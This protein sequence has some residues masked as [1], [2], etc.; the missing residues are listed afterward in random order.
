M[1]GIDTTTT[2]LTKQWGDVY[3]HET[4]NAHIRRLEEEDFA[5]TRLCETPSQFRCRMK[6]I[7]NH[8]NS[9]DFK[10]QGGRGLQGLARELH[11]RCTEVVRR[12]G[13]RLPK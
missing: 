9:D 4:V 13:E 11:A 10:M 1:G 6:R 7:E 12:K 3:L 8:M 2:W 5:C